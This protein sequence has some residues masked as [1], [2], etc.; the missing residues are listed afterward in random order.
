MRCGEGDG[1]GGTPPA[2]PP[3]ITVLGTGISATSYRQ[4][5]EAVAAWARAGQSA[6]ICVCNVHTVMEAHRNPEYARIL[7]EAAIATPD[8]MPLVWALRRLGAPG[9]ERVYGPDLLLE[10]AKLAASQPDLTSYFYGGAEGVAERLAAVLTER[11]PGF[12]VAGFESPPF[13]ELTLEEDAAAVARINASGANV[14]WVGLGAPKQERWMAAHLGRV[15]PVMIGVGAAFDF[16]T[17]RTPQ[18][19]RWMMRMGLEWAF[20]LATEPRRLWRRYLVNNPG[21]VWHVGWQVVLVRLALG[22]RPANTD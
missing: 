21:F 13:R 12:R 6:Y 5:C 8:G 15:R 20:R 17:G 9:Q 19:P 3:K 4:V 7:N 22:Q 11:F 10:F 18:A 2:A 1:T 14:L 16:L